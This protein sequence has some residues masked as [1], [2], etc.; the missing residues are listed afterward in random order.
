VVKNGSLE[1]KEGEKKR[2]GRDRC[3]KR[4][5]EIRRKKCL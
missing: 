1:K 4:K 2:E 5:D 3:T